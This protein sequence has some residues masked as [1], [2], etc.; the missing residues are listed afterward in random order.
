MLRRSFRQLT[1][2]HVYHHVSITLVTAAFLRHDVNGDNYLPAL[3]NSLVHV[4]MYSHYL[5]AAFGVDTWWKKQL[6]SLQLVQFSTVVV[7]S[8][9]AVYRGDAC[10]YA[11]WLKVRLRGA[12]RRAPCTDARRQVLMIAYQLS[13]LGLFGAFFYK[14]YS[15]T[16]RRRKAKGKGKVT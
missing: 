3:A 5:C 4:L 13:M 14:S 11:F 7:Q 16:A 6:T 8:L 10:G 9:L 1:F 12:A 15:E 2:L